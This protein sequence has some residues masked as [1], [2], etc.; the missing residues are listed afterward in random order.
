LGIA[1]TGKTYFDLREALLSFGLDD[2]G[3]RRNRIRL[4]QVRM[5]FPFDSV[6]AKAF[7]RGLEQILVVEEKRAFVET[8]LKEALYD[9]DARPRIVGKSDEQG[10]PLVPSD[11]ALDADLIADLEQA[12]RASARA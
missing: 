2:D 10:G 7:G 1:A 3:L 5:P 11:G 8:F 9:S 6:G 4:F 12:L